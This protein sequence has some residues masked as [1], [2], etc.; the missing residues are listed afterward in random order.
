MLT[1]TEKAILELKEII[2]GP[3]MPEKAGIRVFASSSGCCSGNQLG[4]E[5]ADLSQ[6]E[7]N[8]QD[9]NG[10]KIVMDDATQL[11]AD[12]ATIDFYE[13]TQ[14]PGFR[15]LWQKKQDGSPCGCAS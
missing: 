15:V 12:T 9:Y 5:I 3:G 14:N 6:D 11:I 10:V 4:I 8:V 2:A 7:K 1:I 13:D